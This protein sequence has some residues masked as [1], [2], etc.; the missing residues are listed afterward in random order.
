MKKIYVT[1]PDHIRQLDTMQAAC[2]KAIERNDQAGIL[3]YSH[4]QRDFL[5]AHYPEAQQYP[6]RGLWKTPEEP[7][8][9]VCFEDL[10]EYGSF[11]GEKKPEATVSTF[12]TKG[13]IQEVIYGR[14]PRP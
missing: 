14:K 13:K 10:A 12:L 11:Q 5:A 9:I 1:N 3:K 4:A 6:L 7:L 8:H 2:E